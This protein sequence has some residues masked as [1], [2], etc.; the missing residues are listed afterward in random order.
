MNNDCIKLA[1]YKHLYTLIIIALIITSCADVNHI[2]SCTT[3][4]VYGFFGGFWHGLIAPFSIFGRILGNDIAVYA[5]NNNGSW[6]DV[7]FILGAGG[8][9][10]LLNTES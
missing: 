4:H 2:E 3:G 5:L 7:G 8:F 6:Y 9:G 10:R 1:K